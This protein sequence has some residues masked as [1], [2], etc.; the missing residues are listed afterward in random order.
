MQP[1]RAGPL[2]LGTGHCQAEAG[3]RNVRNLVFPDGSEYW[4]C[5][6]CGSG[7]VTKVVE[8][9]EFPTLI[10]AGTCHYCG[11]RFD[12]SDKHLRPTRD[13][14]IPR[15]LGGPDDF[16]NI[17][18]SCARCNTKKKDDWPTCPCTKCNTARLIFRRNL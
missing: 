3:R 9:Q 17:Q 18:R 4:I 7:K 16:W 1:A 8:G 12:Q 11:E 6:Q 5:I 2:I 14:I 15:A 13:H 10:K